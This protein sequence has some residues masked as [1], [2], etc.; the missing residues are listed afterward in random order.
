MREKE[1]TNMKVCCKVAVN[2]NQRD[3]WN[4]LFVWKIKNESN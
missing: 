4:F 1:K 3:I 2:T